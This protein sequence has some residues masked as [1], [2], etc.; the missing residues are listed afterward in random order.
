MCCAVLYY[1]VL[2]CAWRGVVFAD[3]VCGYCLDVCLCLTQNNGD[4]TQQARNNISQGKVLSW[5]RD[6]RTSRSTDRQIFRLNIEETQKTNVPVVRSLR[7]LRSQQ[8][9]SFP[10]K[11]RQKTGG[12]A[13]SKGKLA[14]A[15]R[16]TSPLHLLIRYSPDAVFAFAGCRLLWW[17]A[18]SGCYDRYDC[19]GCARCAC[20]SG[21]WP[22]PEFLQLVFV[23]IDCN[24]C[25]SSSPV[26]G[27]KQTVS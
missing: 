20:Y 11:K 14:T 17:A 15:H 19:Y 9:K 1:A 16:K 5:H 3:S 24:A 27:R 23:P 6:P 10:R 26:A 12:Q 21:V 7:F 4:R 8:C 18:C 22:G 25:R 2:C 13:A